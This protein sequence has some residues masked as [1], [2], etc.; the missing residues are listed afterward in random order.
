MAPLSKRSQASSCLVTQHLLDAHV[1]SC[2][3]FTPL[4]SID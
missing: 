1:S 4:A 3:V 2:D